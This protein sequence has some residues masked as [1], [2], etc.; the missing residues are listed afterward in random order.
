MKSVVMFA[1]FIFIV[2]IIS[3]SQT[4]TFTVDYNS[5]NGQFKD[6]TGINVGPDKS[7][8]GYIYSGAK[9]VRTHDY[10]GPCDY[11]V[12]TNFFDT[13][14]QTFNA[15]FNPYNPSDYSWGSSDS[16][17]DSIVRFGMTPY[18]RLGY[19]YPQLGRER[20]V[21]LVPPFDPGSP[22][23]YKFAG[24]CK[25]TIMHYTAGWNSGYYYNIPYWEILNEPDNSTFW[26]GTPQNYYNLYKTVSDTI[27]AYNPNLKIGGP[28]IAPLTT[29][30]H[31]KAYFDNFI[32]FCKLNNLKLDFF[33]WHMYG[34]T[35]PY[36][37]KSYATLLNMC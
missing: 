13:V 5:D 2:S 16:K 37:L 11:Q 30:A 18:F 35:N 26:K 27:K 10:Y 8:Q 31:Q 15:A 23:F 4:K 24:L 28:G 14:T 12:Y 20:Q 3:Y 17:I 19:S 33:S 9:W 6:L 36:S 7:V 22:T 21:P 34:L 29:V 1:F 32:S 25:A